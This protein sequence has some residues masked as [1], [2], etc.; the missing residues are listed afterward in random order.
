MTSHKPP[1]LGAA[2]YPED[3]PLDQIDDDIAL[4]RQAGMTV[5]RIGE[6]AWSR[7]EPVEGQFELDWLHLVVDKL[8]EAGIATI[9]CTPTCTPP[10]WLV[11]SHPEVLAVGDNGVPAQHGARRHACPINAT[12]RRYCAAITLRLAQEFGRDV[13]VIGWQIDNELYPY[14]KR[15]CC[16]PDCQRAFRQ[17]LVAQ[18]GTVNALTAAWGTDLWSQTYGSFEEVPLPPRSDTWHH[19]SL[20]TA[21]MQ[22]QSASYVDFCHHQADILHREAAQPVGTDMMPFGGLNYWDIHRKLDIAQFNHY[23]SMD[24]L[25]QSAF[26]MDL[27][28][29]LKDRPFWNTETA[30]CWNGSTMANGV[31]E[32]G[33]CRANSW[34][35]IALGGEANLY[36]LWRAHWSGQELMHGSVVSSCGRPL[37]I[38]NE[39]REIADGLEKA[40]GF[41]N[42]TQPV[43]SG[44]AL[45]FSGFAWNLFEF[46]P[47]VKGFNYSGRL[48]DGY[49][50][51]LLHSQLRPDVIDPRASLAPYRLVCSPFLPAIDEGALAERIIPWVEAGGTWV[52]GPLSDIR[53]LDATKYR[54]APYGHLEEW[55]GVTCRYELPG[56][57]KDYLLRW[58]DGHCSQGSIWYDG[59]EVTNA[60]SLADYADGPL[61]GLA[62]ITRRRVG[63]GQI[64]VL[65]T[66]PRPEDLATLL[67]GL[68]KDAGVTPAC[69][70]S[71]NLLVVPRVGSAGSGMVVVE[72]EHK[73][74]TLHLG[75]P[76]FDLLTKQT[77]AGDLTVEPYGVKVLRFNT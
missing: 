13:N 49:Y 48:L 53:T 1:Y 39:V 18:F 3:W 16:C 66:L 22:F 27:C 68:A 43:N 60:E 35:P 15:G 37:H 28:R 59:L 67:L 29:P 42:G 77:C 63:K 76:A 51:P 6:F 65:G 71:P 31:K 47:L 4:M 9:L 24:N 19:P 70:A 72:L 52:V 36:W 57:P 10:A 46:Q 62:A 61:A 56:D 50:H 64:V 2:Y 25:W 14:G 33:F 7:M 17:S 41:L 40:A 32:P 69:Q 23:N 26:W 73:P 8:G 12:Y 20:Q 74:A 21:W 11:G 75:Q 38:F 34:L 55:A 30:T 45:H 5:M 44:L 58:S 54:H